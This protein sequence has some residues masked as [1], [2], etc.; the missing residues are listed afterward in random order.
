M[1]RLTRLLGR[2]DVA[3]GGN[4]IRAG[5]DNAIGEHIVHRLSLA[6]GHGQTVKKGNYQ[7]P[8]QGCG[9]QVRVFRRAEHGYGD[10]V[11]HTVSFSL[12]IWPYDRRIMT[13]HAE[14]HYR[15]RGLGAPASAGLPLQPS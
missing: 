11:F 4:D 5:Q 1:V 3:A 13:R 6:Q 8:T 7:D 14:A 9:V 12:S 15:R 10:N 2:A